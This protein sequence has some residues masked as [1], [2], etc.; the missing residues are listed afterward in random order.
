MALSGR[1]EKHNKISYFAAATARVIIN[2]PTL[3]GCWM[4]N[5]VVF[6]LS[7]WYLGSLTAVSSVL[8]EVQNSY[9]LIM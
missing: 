4:L 5:L 1:Q 2:I 9:I 7:K 8:R 3:P 6:K